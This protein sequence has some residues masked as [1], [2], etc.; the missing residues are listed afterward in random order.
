MSKE[1]ALAA[2]TGQTA[3][4]A[5]PQTPPPE[6]QKPVESDRFAVLASKEAKLQKEREAVKAEKLAVDTLKAELSKYKGEIDEF[7]TLKKTDKIAALK[8]IGFTEEDILNFVAGKEEPTPPTMEA[9]S[10][11]HLTLPTNREV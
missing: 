9:V 2:M 8:K 7:E 4:V 10:Y 1:T 6:A 11:T 5:A 3:P